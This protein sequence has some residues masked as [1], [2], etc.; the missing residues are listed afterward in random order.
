MAFVGVVSCYMVDVVCLRLWW[1]FDV[2][3]ADVVQVQEQPKNQRLMRK[4]KAVLN[5]PQM[6]GLR[7]S[8][9]RPPGYE[10]PD[11]EYLFK[12]KHDDDGW[13]TFV[14]LNG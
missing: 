13:L 8:G 2:E 4:K 14:L 7:I 10:P 11:A 6:M 3:Q 1:K 12:I 9:K 5:V